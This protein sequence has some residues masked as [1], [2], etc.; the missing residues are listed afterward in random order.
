MRRSAGIAVLTLCVIAG[1]PQWAS[2]AKATPD[3]YTLLLAYHSHTV[4]VSLNPNVKYRAADDF[5][6][7]TQAT[8][9]GLVLVVNPQLPVRSVRELIAYGKANPNK[10]NFSSAGTGSGG[11]MAAELFKQMAGIQA[12]HVPYKGTGPSLVDLV[13][14]QIQASFAGMVP[15]QPFIRGGRVRALAVTSARRVPALPDLPT[16]AESGLAGFEVIGWYGVLAPAGVP[17]Q[18]VAKLNG[19]IVNV[20]R[21]PEVKKRLTSDGAEVVASTPEE[22]ERFL[23]AD[24]GKWAKVV[25]ATGARLD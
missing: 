10:L 20:L 19:E 25:K 23:R 7:I 12:Q 15:V 1:L 13:S 21:D 18:I 9:A 11:H 6:P 2:A 14:G 4:N 3:G 22:F 8:I 5:Q 24:V 16:V 17:R